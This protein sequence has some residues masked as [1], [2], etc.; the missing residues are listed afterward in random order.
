MAHRWACL[1]CILGMQTRGIVPVQNALNK[2]II[3][4]LAAADAAGFPVYI[5]IG[6]E[7]TD[8]DGDPLQIAPG[9]WLYTNKPTAETNIYKLDPSDLSPLI[10]LK[11]TFVMEIARISRVPLSAF[12]VT[13]N[14]AAEGTMK[15]Q[16]SG[17]IAKAKDRQITFGN[18]WEDVMAMARRLHNTFGNGSLDE[19]VIISTVWADPETRNDKEHLE[20]LTLMQGLGVPEEKLWE[21]MDKFSAK[22]IADMKLL[23][24]EALAQ[25]SNIGGELLRAFE[26]GGFGGGGIQGGLDEQETANQGA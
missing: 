2:T 9:T 20:T 15:Q 16:E 4:I 19:E 8:S 12:Q 5:M 3:D 17:L 25:T 13:G 26:G 11:D 1:S 23:R 7:P 10:A 24:A 21:L 6:D 14:I 18:A 22:D